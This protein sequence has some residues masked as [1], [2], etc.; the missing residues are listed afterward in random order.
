LFLFF[1]GRVLVARLPNFKTGRWLTDA[2]TGTLLLTVCS[3]FASISSLNE[4]GLRPP[5]TKFK[6]NCASSDDRR[7]RV[8]SGAERLGKGQLSLGARTVTENQRRD[9]SGGTIFFFDRGQGD[10][11][12]RCAAET[13]AQQQRTPKALA[14]TGTRPSPDGNAA[15]ATELSLS[16][17]VLLAFQDHE[18]V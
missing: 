14:E 13:P 4:P 7:R 10:A 15:R 5:H 12:N 17:G 6:A 2:R 16:F 3:G 1:A 11:S 18:R 8:S 9:G